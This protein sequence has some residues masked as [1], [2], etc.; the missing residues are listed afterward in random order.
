VIYNGAKID[1]CW[2]NYGVIVMPVN[3]SVKNVPDVVMEKLRQRAKRHHRSL[4]G[5]IMVILEEAAGPN[6]LSLDE[7]EVRLNAMKFGT[8]DDSRLWIRELRDGR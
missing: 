5:E 6:L 8:G 2:N 7:A 1:V 4:Q 3:V